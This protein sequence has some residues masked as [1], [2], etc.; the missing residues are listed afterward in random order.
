MSWLSCL[1]TTRRLSRCVLVASFRA[2]LWLWPLLC[3]CSR[4]F[5]VSVSPSSSSS[6]PRH[7]LSPP[8][9]PPPHSLLTLRTLRTPLRSSLPPLFLRLDRAS[10]AQIMQELHTRSAKKCLE[11]ARE[12]GGL[13]TKA[14]QFVASLQVS[15]LCDFE[16]L[17][18]GASC[19]PARTSVVAWRCNYTSFCVLTPACHGTRTSVQSRKY[20]D[21]AGRSTDTGVW[22]YQGG[23]GDQGIPKPYVDVL[24]VLTDAAPVSTQAVVAFVLLMA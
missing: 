15:L 9:S 5:S 1:R 23:A 12:N 7:S 19:E 16:Q 2:S 22:W 21:T 11:L 6:L 17:P 24:R 10:S 4:D 3:S 8:P 14:A 20:A 13:Y 18:S